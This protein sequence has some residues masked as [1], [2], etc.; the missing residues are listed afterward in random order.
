LSIYDVCPTSATHLQDGAV[1]FS[2]EVEV[3]KNLIRGYSVTSFLKLFSF[4]GGLLL[5]LCFVDCNIDGFELKFAD[6]LYSNKTVQIWGTRK[7]T[8]DLKDS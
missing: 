1:F 6:I 5:A 2:V 3:K 7:D 4:C 8:R